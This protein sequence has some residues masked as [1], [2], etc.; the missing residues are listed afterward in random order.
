LGGSTGDDDSAQLTEWVKNLN[1]SSSVTV[2]KE[3]AILL[4]EINYQMY[5]D[6]QIQERILMTNSIMLLQN[7]K[8]SQPSPPN[9][10]DET[11]SNN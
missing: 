4:A 3:I 5:L 1:K 11:S 8:S 6:R 9:S 2:Q 7:M 10:S